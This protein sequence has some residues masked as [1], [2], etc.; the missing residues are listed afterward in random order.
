MD[1]FCNRCFYFSI[2]FTFSLAQLSAPVMGD[3]Y[4]AAPSSHDTIEIRIRQ[5]LREKS[6]SGGKGSG[7]MSRRNF[8]GALIGT[9]GALLMNSVAQA[10]VTDTDAEYVVVDPGND[11][12]DVEKFSEDF[13]VPE[14]HIHVLEFYTA[15]KIK[16]FCSQRGYTRDSKKNITYTKHYRNIQHQRRFY[17]VQLSIPVESEGSRK[18]IDF[19]IFYHQNAYKG[20]D[21][22]VI[23]N[24]QE[25]GFPMMVGS[26]MFDGIFW[27][28]L[29]TDNEHG[30]GVVTNDADGEKYV[31]YLRQQKQQVRR[32]KVYAGLFAAGLFYSGLREM[33]KFLRRRKDL[34][35]QR[36]LA[37]I[38]QHLENE[39]FKDG[40]VAMGKI[41]F[42]ILQQ[43][44]EHDGNVEVPIMMINNGI[45]DE[46]IS[47]ARHIQFVEETLLQR[48]LDEG[49]A[50]YALAFYYKVLNKFLQ[51]NGGRSILR[52]QDG[53]KNFLL[54]L[55]GSLP[56]DKRAE[57]LM[58]AL[59]DVG[60][61][62]V[63]DDSVLVGAIAESL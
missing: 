30:K 16:E 52:T 61:E 6:S 47:D 60:A 53:V 25:F 51:D 13:N 19:F 63:V 36:K 10:R 24:D 58:Y 37:S 5:E 7:R 44:E 9:G 27:R 2:L 18:N 3:M 40:A 55:T 20:R 15:G 39:P 26:I 35:T 14:E 1:V 32:E 23:I 22:I 4:L 17:C 28:D 54:A 31:A 49:L 38:R 59:P 33:E 11:F 21:H 12:I 46:Y 8:F 43:L 50:W 34:I 56:A 62:S 42:Y 29:T 48:D 57:A 41:A 45:V